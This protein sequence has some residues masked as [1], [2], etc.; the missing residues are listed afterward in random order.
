MNQHSTSV[1]YCG[2]CGA[3]TAYLIECQDR[4]GMPLDVLICSHCGVVHNDPIPS[5]N[6]LSRFYAEQYRKSYKGTR[7]PKLRHAARYFPAV[8]SHIKE[9][10]KH[11]QSVS[12]V[13]DVGSGSGEFLY[14]MHKLGK[15]AVGLE[16]T[17]DYA[18]FC[19][20]RFGLEVI[21]G[22]I[23]DFQPQ[24][25]FDHIRLCHVVEHLPD[26]V[27]S[28]RTIS[29]WLVESGTMHVSVPDFKTYC[30]KKTPGRIFHYGHIYNF[31]HD[32]FE[33]LIKLSGLEILE[34]L[35]PTSAFLRR[36]SRIPDNDPLLNWKITDKIEFYRQCREGK[37]RARSCFEKCVTKILKSMKEHRIMATH[38]SHVTVANQASES[39]RRAL[40]L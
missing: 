5:V 37:H 17:K 30:R 6:E 29:D 31:D 19:R 3:S 10:W 26:P 12:R 39:L 8:A 1:S 18:Q 2:L 36:S 24:V 14:L 23:G 9:H 20:E 15:Q 27:G 11:Y 4:N 35:G 21:T 32:T 7:R 28:L 34:R 38:R 25:K 22:E 16:P 40:L 13:L 33:F